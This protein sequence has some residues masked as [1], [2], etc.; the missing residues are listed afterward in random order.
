MRITVPVGSEAIVHVPATNDQEVFESGRKIA[1]VPEVRFI[2]EKD[3]YILYKVGSGKYEFE[4][5]R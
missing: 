4:V 2:E 3:N 1:D 5:L